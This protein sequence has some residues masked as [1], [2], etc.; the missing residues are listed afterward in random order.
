[1]LGEELGL[2]GALLVIGLFIVLGIGMF[3][4]AYN[5]NDHFVRISTGAIMTWLL[6]QAFMNIAMVTGL[7]PVIGVPLPF[8]SAGGSALLMAILAVGVVLS[9]AREQAHKIQQH[10]NT[11]LSSPVLKESVQST[12]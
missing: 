1:M 10:A 7:L 12:E 4:V 9:F 8:I 11:H 6:G 5:T 3:R 2:L